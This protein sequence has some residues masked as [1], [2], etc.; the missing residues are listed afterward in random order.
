MTLRLAFITALLAAVSSAAQGQSSEQ[1]ARHQ[2]AVA[3]SEAD[4]VAKY[5]ELGVKDSA[6]NKAFLEDVQ[7]KAPEDLENADHWPMD[8]ADEIF[9]AWTAESRAMPPAAAQ[10]T[11]PGNSTTDE[12]QEQQWKQI[13]QELKQ[14]DQKAQQ[15]YEQ[16]KQQ[17]DRLNQEEARIR[18]QLQQQPSGIEAA[19]TSDSDRLE[20]IEDPAGEGAAAMRAQ[21]AQAAEKQ[22]WIAEQMRSQA[23][24]DEQSSDR[25]ASDD[26][27]LRNQINEL[28]QEQWWQQMNQ[29]AGQFMQDAWRQEQAQQ[30][31]QQISGEIERNEPQINNHSGPDDGYLRNQINE[32]QEEQQWQQMKQDSDQFMPDAWQQAQHEQQIEDSGNAGLHQ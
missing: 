11:P 23:R 2:A 9:A 20:N 30:E 31:L 19:D 1:S 7:K 29:R 10:Q 24:Q 27:Y 16:D 18:Q 13:Q 4:A 15:E 5:P 21:Q 32:L 3:L 12:Q 25:H 8:I 17:L 22:E 28:Q 14:E 6:F 26:G